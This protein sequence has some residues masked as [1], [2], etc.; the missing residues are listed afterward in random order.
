[1]AQQR[2]SCFSGQHTES[3]AR[4]QWHTD[5]LFHLLDAAACGAERKVHTGRAMRDAAGF[6]HGHEQP[7]V[8][9]IE[10]HWLSP[11]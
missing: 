11:L 2:M 8:C 3:L 10:T 6:H 1:M 9:Y 5:S 7:Q 4:E